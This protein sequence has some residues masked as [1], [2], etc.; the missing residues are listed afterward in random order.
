MPSKAIENAK[1]NTPDTPEN[2]LVN[3]HPPA[4]GACAAGTDGDF[5]PW[6]WKRGG[7]IKLVFTGYLG[8]TDGQLQQGTETPFFL[9]PLNFCQYTCSTKLAEEGQVRKCMKNCT[10]LGDEKCKSPSG[11]PIL[12][13]CRA[14]KAK[15][16]GIDQIN[17]TFD[18]VEK[19]TLKNKERKIL[20]DT[21]NTITTIKI[22]GTKSAKWFTRANYMNYLENKAKTGTGEHSPMEYCKDMCDKHSDQKSRCLEYCPKYFVN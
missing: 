12:D 18:K 19:E 1:A 2:E 21:N 6:I 9:T 15:M 20:R 14:D 11:A 8:Y 13:W 17:A 3:G 4:D 7:G 10:Y 16:R 22:L 5:W